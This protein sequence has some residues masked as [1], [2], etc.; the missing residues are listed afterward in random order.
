MEGLTIHLGQIVWGVDWTLGDR[1][2][3]ILSLFLFRE[4]IISGPA[5]FS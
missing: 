1:I 2:G 5:C 3:F 4:V